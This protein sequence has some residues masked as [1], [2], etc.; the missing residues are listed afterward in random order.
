MALLRTG[1]TLPTEAIERT[2]GALCRSLQ[3]ST[4]GDYIRFTKTCERLM[5]A[6]FGSWAGMSEAQIHALVT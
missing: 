5:G 6:P 1:S 2:A 4:L 3:P